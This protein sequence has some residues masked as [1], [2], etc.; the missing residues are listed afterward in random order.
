M[1]P[2]H[3]VIEFFEKSFSSSF[4]LP[5]DRGGL[6][7]QAKNTVEKILVAL[8]LNPKVFKKATDQNYDF[9][10]LH[11]PPLWEPLQKLSCDDPLFVMLEGLYSRGISVLAHHTNLDVL[12]GGIA[13]QWVK[14]LELEGSTRPLVPLTHLKKYK[15][16]TFVPPSHL[17]EVLQA[18]FEQGAGIIGNY[19]ECAF[20]LSGTG[21]F[22]PGEKAYPFI[23]TPGCRERVEEVR[24]EV[25]VE[26]P[27][28]E[29]AVKAL[30]RAHPYEEP[31]VDVYP[32][33]VLSRVGI[34]RVVTLATPLPWKILEERLSRLGVPH[35]LIGSREDKSFAKIALCPGSGRG[36][37][38]QVLQGRPDLFVS[39]DL[40]HH[41]IETLNL[42]GIAHVNLPHSEGER[43][44]L[45]EITGSLKEKAKQEN[46]NVEITFEEEKL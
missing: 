18:L 10:Y 21:T 4:A 27:Y 7:I 37:M 30:I 41:D 11:H 17:E 2:L 26:S 31:V 15:I 39:G 43:R 40:T 19:R 24:V 23:G 29:R 35:T 34:G 1:E 28:L 45:R 13:D 38:S 9:L 22:L 20:L 36:V 6:Q 14:L 25:E 8:E 32:L 46:L 16:V 42:Y 5:E 3:R 44:A 12:E 33:H